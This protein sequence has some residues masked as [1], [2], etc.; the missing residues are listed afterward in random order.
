MSALHQAAL[1]GN[2]DIMRL[3]LEHGAVVDISDS[4]SKSPSHHT[5]VTARIELTAHALT[6]GPLPLRLRVALRGV[7]PAQP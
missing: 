6:W 3:L 2:I 5:H 1:S 4:N 7:N